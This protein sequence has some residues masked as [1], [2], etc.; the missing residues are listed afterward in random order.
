MKKT[1]FMSLLLISSIFAVDDYIIELKGKTPEEIEAITKEL[2]TKDPSATINKKV[3]KDGRFL[4]VGLDKT[5]D[6]TADTGK[7]IYDAEC[8]RCHGENGEK[9]SYPTAERLS[10]MSAKDIYDS[11]RLYAIDPSYG[12]SSRMV[13]QTISSKIMS[14]DLGYIIAYLKGEEFAT[15]ANDEAYNTEIQTEPTEQGS[16]IR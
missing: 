10:Q 3:Q 6:Y 11:F 1:L 7:K 8:K 5:I 16:Y 12:G 15:I 13:M 4:G 2:E 14:K 9:R